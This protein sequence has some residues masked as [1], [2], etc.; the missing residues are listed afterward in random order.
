[1]GLGGLSSGRVWP[2]SLEDG[3]GGDGLVS[4]CYG[5]MGVMRCLCGVGSSLLSGMCGVLGLF[6]G[7]A[8]REEPR[9]SPKNQKHS[10]IE[11][12]CARISSR[13]H[14]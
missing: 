6:A 4:G 3:C 14:G 12:A 13:L 1:M 7:D 2:S 10:I 11:L 8:V 5:F 9:I